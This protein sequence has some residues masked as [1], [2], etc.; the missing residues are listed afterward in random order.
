MPHVYKNFGIE[1]SYPE[2]WTVTE[3][4]VQDWPR[5]VSL[6]SPEN[7]IW[8]LHIH[9]HSEPRALAEET[10]KTMREEYESLECEPTT[11]LIEDVEVVGFDMNF[12]C[13]DFLVAARTRSFDL[14]NLTLL[15]LYQAEDR[16]FERLDPVFYAI[17]L[18]LLR[19]HRRLQSA[20]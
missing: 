1:F 20:D 7:A 4:E 6:E 14:G 3:E 17:M 18:S 10:L 12:Y 13:L 15:L 2:N 5:L 19:G 16:D 8:A 11:D 9:Q